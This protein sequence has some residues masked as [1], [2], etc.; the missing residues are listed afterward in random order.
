MPGDRNRFVDIEG[1]TY[2]N[3]WLSWVTVQELNPAQLDGDSGVGRLATP[4]VKDAVVNKV[5]ALCRR[6]L[7]EIE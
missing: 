1:A 6:Y 5:M 7:N 4:E 3:W 2:N